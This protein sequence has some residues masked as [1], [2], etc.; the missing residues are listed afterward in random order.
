M[1]FFLYQP[2]DTFIC[3]YYIQVFHGKTE[4][5]EEET[6][7]EKGGQEEGTEEEKGSTQE[8]TTKMCGQDQ[9]R[10]EM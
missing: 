3:K 2:I 9:G 5:S 1:Q 8:E 4:S 7:Q 6:S 10:Q